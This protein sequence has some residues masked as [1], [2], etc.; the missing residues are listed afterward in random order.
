[1]ATAPEV[2]LRVPPLPLVGRNDISWGWMGFMATAPEV[3]LRVPPLPLVGRNDISLGVDGV[4][5]DC[6]GRATAGSS[7]PF[8]RLE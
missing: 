7:T 1:M 8:G 5:G 4:Y 2:Q 3:Q 6:V